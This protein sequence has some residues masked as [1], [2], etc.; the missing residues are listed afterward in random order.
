MDIVFSGVPLTV[1]KEGVVKIKNEIAEPIFDVDVFLKIC[2]NN[3]YYKIQDIIAMVYMEYDIS[4]KDRFVTHIDKNPR[5]NHVSNLKI[6]RMGSKR[7]VENLT[8]G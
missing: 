1:Y 7:K 5:N 8:V 6:E 4:E 3:R 2:I